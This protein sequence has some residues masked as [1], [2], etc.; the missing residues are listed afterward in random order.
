MIQRKT[1]REK[2]MEN[3]GVDLYEDYGYSK[4]LLGTVSGACVCVFFRNKKNCN[5]RIK[6]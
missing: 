4:K 5:K 2:E 3:C 6:C 1:E